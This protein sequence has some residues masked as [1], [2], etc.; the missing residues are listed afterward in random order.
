M[1]GVL[2][3]ALNT[4]SLSKESEDSIKERREAEIRVAQTIE[5]LESLTEIEEIKSVEEIPQQYIKR[6]VKD[7]REL[8]TRKFQEPIEKYGFVNSNIEV[9]VVDSSPTKQYT[10]VPFKVDFFLFIIL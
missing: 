1:I 8:N 7:I 10:E 5:R 3:V 6:H 2:N 9:T 4:R